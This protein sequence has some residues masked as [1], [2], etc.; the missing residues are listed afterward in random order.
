MKHVATAGN[1]YYDVLMI[2]LEKRYE[3]D[4]ST[5]FL[6]HGYA[7]LTLDDER[8]SK[9]GTLYGHAWIER[10]TQFNGHMYAEC[11]SVF[12]EAVLHLDTFYHHGKIDPEN[13]TRYTMAEVR[14]LVLVS[15]HSGPWKDAPDETVF[16]EKVTGNKGGD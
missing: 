13:V 16:R 10:E 4:E 12:P 11:I 5:C 3:R 1:C 2:F 9:A 8:G 14:Q 15:G 7:R 6:A